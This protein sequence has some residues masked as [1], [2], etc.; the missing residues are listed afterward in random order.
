MKKLLLS[1]V[2][3]FAVSASYAQSL[4]VYSAD[5]SGNKVSQA[6][7]NGN[8]PAVDYTFNGIPGME[9]AQYNFYVENTSSVGGTMYFEATP[10]NDYAENNITIGFCYDGRCTSVSTG[11]TQIEANGYYNGG[12][13]GLFDMTASAKQSIEGT[14]DFKV[15]FTLEGETASTTVYFSINYKNPSGIAS[16][17]V[18]N[19][20]KVFQDESGNVVVDYGFGND[21]ERELSIVSLAGQTL[22]SCAVDGAS[23]N[24]VLPVNLGKGVY[25]YSVTE[26]GRVLSSHKLVVR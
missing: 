24:M 8:L 9:Q 23:G 16:A 3:L 1:L 13:M 12:G 26:G 18:V 11:T 10:M 25:L 2:A 19:N 7:E 22:Y 21:A 20:L 17:E 15:E 5:H 14:A 6:D 4:V